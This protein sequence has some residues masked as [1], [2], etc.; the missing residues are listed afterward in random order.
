VAVQADNYNYYEL[1]FWH[2][3]FGAFIELASLQ[4]FHAPVL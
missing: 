1:H 4:I 3:G 2:A